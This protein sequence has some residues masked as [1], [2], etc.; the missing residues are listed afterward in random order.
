MK[1]GS[2]FFG[3]ILVLF[4]LLLLL[5]NLN[6][7]GDFNF[8]STLGPIL[9]IAFGAW[10]LLGFVAKPALQA[11]HVAFPLHGAR[12]SSL[13]IKHGAGRLR[14]SSG[15]PSDQLFEGDFSGGVEIR[16]EPQGEQLNLTLAMPAPKLFWNWGQ[17]GFDWRI[18]LNPQIP[19]DLEV[20]SGAVDSNLD[21]SGL[22][23]KRFVLKTGASNN[24][25]ILP[26]REGVTQVRIEAGVS[27]VSIR[28][29]EG[30]AARIQTETGLAGVTIDRSRFPL[31]GG[32][33]ISPDYEAAARKIDL[34]VVTGL[35]SVDI[36]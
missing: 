32:F 6:L 17:G 30:V 19:L 7:L 16:G 21:L 9:L 18:A 1:R 35:G 34:K 29:P 22:D 28:I 31:H 20:N 12:S 8:W 25:V 5:D 23:V 11:E 10:L 24:Q 13:Q 27:A 33:K 15:A 4:G 36:R 14:I 2:F 26:S 3:G